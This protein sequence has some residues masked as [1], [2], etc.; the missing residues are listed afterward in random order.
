[1]SGLN[2]FSY[3]PQDDTFGGIAK[4]MVGIS[5]FMHYPFTGVSWVGHKVKNFFGAQLDKVKSA[6]SDIGPQFESIQ[7]LS[8]SGDVEGLNSFSYEPGEDNPLGGVSSALV[9]I[10]RIMHY[11]NAGIHWVG[12][13]VKG[14]IDDGVDKAK[15]AISNTASS[16]EDLQGYM[17]SGDPDS[18]LSYLPD[19]PEDAPVGGMIKG[20]IGVAKYAMLPGA[21]IHKIGNKIG[22]FITEKVS[23]R[24]YFSNERLYQYPNFLYGYR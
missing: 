23:E 20:I 4:V 21:Y 15:T 14:F 3:E 16:V 7:A 11:P 5:K 6:F 2:N 22:D 24:Y 13:K 12:N 8:K 18:I 1:M 17:K 10:D 9:N 19:I